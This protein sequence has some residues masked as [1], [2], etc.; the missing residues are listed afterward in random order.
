MVRPHAALDSDTFL[1]ENLII[2]LLGRVDNNDIPKHMMITVPS[3]MTLYELLD[4]IAVKI[5][6]SP[7]RL[8]ISRKYGKAEI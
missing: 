3:N 4:Y 5:N 1:I 6:K 8:E 2:S 7:L